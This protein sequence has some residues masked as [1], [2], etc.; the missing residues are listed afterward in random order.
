MVTQNLYKETKYL[1]PV[2]VTQEMTKTLK[3]HE[4]CDLIIC[5]SHLGHNYKDNPNKICDV[6][7]AKSTKDIDLIIGGHTHTFLNKPEIITN[8]N[9]EKVII[10]QVG[11]F[12]FHRIK[13]EINFT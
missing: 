12:V 6:S 8:I 4:K 2:E 7:L 5:L 10:N 3:E 1:D 11:C 9:G 13:I